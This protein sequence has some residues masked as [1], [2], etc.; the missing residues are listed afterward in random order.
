MTATTVD[1]RTIQLLQDDI[2]CR[3]ALHQQT[4]GVPGTTLDPE[5][6][7]FDYRSQC[8]GIPSLD[9]DVEDFPMRRAVSIDAPSGL[10]RNTAGTRPGARS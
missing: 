5:Y 9:H 2:H 8:R 1:L 10:T 3:K 6:M 4:A 7:T